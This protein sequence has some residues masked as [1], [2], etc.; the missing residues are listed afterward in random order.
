MTKWWPGREVA[1]DGLPH[2]T[3]K[4]VEQGRVGA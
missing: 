3:T 4:P 1:V 2:G